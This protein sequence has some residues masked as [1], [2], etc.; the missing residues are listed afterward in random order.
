M[1]IEPLIQKAIHDE[2]QRRVADAIDV[3]VKK[4]SAEIERRVRSDVGAITANV[5]DH[6]S[7]EKMGSNLIITVKFDKP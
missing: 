2:I 6:F 3:E 7:F 5:C 1:N 4:A